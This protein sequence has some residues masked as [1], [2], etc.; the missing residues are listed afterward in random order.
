MR[1]QFFERMLEPTDRLTLTGRILTALWLSVLLIEFG[2]WLII[3]IVGGL[4]SPWWLWTLVVGGVIVGGF[5]FFVRHAKADK[6][7]RS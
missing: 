6:K 2:V 7:A 4:T 5:H 3:S 1:D